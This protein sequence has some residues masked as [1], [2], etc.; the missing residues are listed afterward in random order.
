MDNDTLYLKT[1]YTIHKCRPCNA[2]C[3]KTG[4]LHY[5]GPGTIVKFST[6]AE[7]RLACF[8]VTV[9]TWL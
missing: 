9:P 4:L 6:Q 2:V 5:F 3:F 1:E 7:T 8:V